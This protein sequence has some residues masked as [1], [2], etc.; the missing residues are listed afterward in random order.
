M[1]KWP[2][3]R[4]GVGRRGPG[5]P[6]RVELA[7]QVLMFDCIERPYIHV[8]GGSIGEAKF[9]LVPT[10]GLATAWGYTARE[11]ARIWV[12]ITQ[13]IL[14]VAIFLNSKRFARIIGR[15]R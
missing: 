7:R 4:P 10:A 1:G 11:L 13:G 5:D 15:Q 8:R 14:V 6:D 2:P 9:W 3:P 12:P